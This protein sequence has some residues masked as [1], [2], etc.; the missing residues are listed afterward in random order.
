MMFFSLNFLHGIDT[1]WY[2]TAVLSRLRLRQVCNTVVICSLMSICLL[3]AQICVLSYVRVNQSILQ[4]PGEFFPCLQ[5][6][7]EVDNSD[8]V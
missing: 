1:L 4:I 3:L 6:V 8:D 7:W 2:E 5:G